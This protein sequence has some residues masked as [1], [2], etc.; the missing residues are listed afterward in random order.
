M[1]ITITEKKIADFII[2][3]REKKVILDRDLADL[4][5]TNTK[6]LNQAIK[7]NQRR[8]PSDFMFTLSKEE[9][10]ELVTNCDRFNLLKHSTSLPNAFTEQGVAMLSSVLSSQRAIDVNLQIMRVF[11]KVREIMLSSNDFKKKIDNM[12]RQLL[13]QNKVQQEHSNHIKMIFAAIKGLTFK[14]DKLKTKRIGF[15]D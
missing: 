10:H 9:K 12:E 11:V 15:G 3:I 2:T 1:S 14:K 7:R 13:K 4:Y 8:F 6:A 5:N